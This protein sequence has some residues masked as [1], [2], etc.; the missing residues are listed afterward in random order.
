MFAT[1]KSLK[2]KHLIRIG[3]VSEITSLGKST[4][5]LWVSQNKFPKPIKISSTL[6]VWELSDISD[7]IS[8]L[9]KRVK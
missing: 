7:W 3:D 9:K 6:K 8:N 2:K 5:N 1:D 4:I